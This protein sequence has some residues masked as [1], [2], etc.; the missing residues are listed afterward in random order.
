MNL[1]HTK[2]ERLSFLIRKLKGKSNKNFKILDLIYFKKAITS[3]IRKNNCKDRKKNLKIKK[4]LL[5]HLH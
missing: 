1:N 3:K 2:A 4:L 5:D